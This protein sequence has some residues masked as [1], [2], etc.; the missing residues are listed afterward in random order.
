MSKIAADQMTAGKNRNPETVALRRP[1]D[2][3]ALE[4]ALLRFPN[5]EMNL[6]DRARRK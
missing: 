5:S 3:E 6:G 4:I 1:P 2:E